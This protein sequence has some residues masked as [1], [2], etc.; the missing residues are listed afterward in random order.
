MLEPGHFHTWRFQGNILLTEPLSSFILF[1]ASGCNELLLKTTSVSGDLQL[2]G[3]SNSEHMY[4]RLHTVW[5][6]HMEVGHCICFTVLVSQTNCLNVSGPQRDSVLFQWMDSPMS[7][8]HDHTC[9]E[10]Y[11]SMAASYLCES[12]RCFLVIIWKQLQANC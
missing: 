5:K 6:F 3:S 8:F 10:N 1:D 11:T 12:Y 9:S 7:Q 4:Y 2:T